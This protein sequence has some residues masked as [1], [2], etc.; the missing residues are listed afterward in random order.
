MKDKI[1]IK[2]E[3]GRTFSVT[4]EQSDEG[5]VITKTGDKTDDASKR[6]IIIETM[7]LGIYEKFKNAIIKDTATSSIFDYLMKFV[8]L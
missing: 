2:K 8:R 3:G 7:D 1:I 4:A 5:I 6:K